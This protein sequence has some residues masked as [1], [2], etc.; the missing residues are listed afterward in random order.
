MSPGF[1]PP[2]PVTM[3][4]AP[5]RSTQAPWPTPSVPASQPVVTRPAPV[6][7]GVMPDESVPA[8]S[9]PKTVTAKLMMP[10]P[11]ELGITKASAKE[12]R[13]DW[14][15]CHR[16]LDALGAQSIHLERLAAG[17][18]QFSCLLPTS[19]QDRCHRVESTAPTQAE[20]VR[21]VLQ[22]A[23]QWVAAR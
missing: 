11:E 23:Q 10:S 5:Y 16:R 19:Q 20:A 8:L 9:Q 4:P 15:E 17:G 22:E 2:L 7:R 3:V 14:A 21:L 12:E 1:A 13:T 18:Y 6:F